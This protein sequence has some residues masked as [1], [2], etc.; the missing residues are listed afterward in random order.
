MENTNKKNAKQKKELKAV[1]KKDNSAYSGS[2][3]FCDNYDSDI[4]TDPLGSWTGGPLDDPYDKPI[5]DADD[6]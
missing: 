5:Q 4:H 6:L 3:L 2:Y 1:S